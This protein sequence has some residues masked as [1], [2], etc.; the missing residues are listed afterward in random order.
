MEHSYEYMMLYP[1]QIRVD[2]KYQREI[3]IGRIKRIVKNWD[4]DLVNAPK[5][6]LR[7]NGLFY[8]FNGQHTLVAWK[9]KY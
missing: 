7:A 3:D 4:D 1:D 9:K 8:V 6:S 5:V 2:P